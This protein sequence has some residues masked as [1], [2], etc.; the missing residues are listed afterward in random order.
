M[1]ILLSYE[2][3]ATWTYS[4]RT[5]GRALL[6]RA[7]ICKANMIIIASLMHGRHCANGEQI[8]SLEVERI[9]SNNKENLVNVFARCAGMENIF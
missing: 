3:L 7:R 4:R 9:I 2:P 6:P 8:S 1:L 5:K